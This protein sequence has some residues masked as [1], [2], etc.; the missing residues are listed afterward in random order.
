MV[1]LLP[2]DGRAWRLETLSDPLEG[3]LQF[4]ECVM[5]AAVGQRGAVDA[6]P[7]LA[8]SFWQLVRWAPTPFE[9]L[10]REPQGKGQPFLFH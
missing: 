10:H 6:L 4:D 5:H 7:L 9:G 3:V 8:S 2:S 1:A